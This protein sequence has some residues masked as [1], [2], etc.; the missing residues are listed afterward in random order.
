MYQGFVEC[1]FSTSGPVLPA[2]NGN[3][4]PRLS[5]H[6]IE[7]DVRQFEKR[8][9]II[10]IMVKRRDTKEQEIFFRTPLWESKIFFSTSE[11]AAVPRRASDLLE[12]LLKQ[13]RQDWVRTFQ[14]AE[15][16]Q[17]KMVSSDKHSSR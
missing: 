5:D 17:A 4:W 2:Y 11:Y 7:F 13:I 3:S 9:G 1:G 15:S 12:P 16:R 8:Y 6:I 10:W 14:E